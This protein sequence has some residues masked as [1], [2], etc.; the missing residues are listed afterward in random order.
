[1]SYSVS[2]QGHVL[3]S[4]TSVT[5]RG[6]FTL[7]SHKLLQAGR[8]SLTVTVTHNHQRIHLT[9]TITAH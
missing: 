8:Y 9:R 5:R 6:S 7:Q 1:M 2:H 3:I 4:G